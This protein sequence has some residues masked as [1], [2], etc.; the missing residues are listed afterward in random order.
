MYQ[1]LLQL[2]TRKRK[3][4]KTK[5]A[6]RYRQNYYVIKIPDSNNTNKR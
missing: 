2:K 4:T 1:Q 5:D 3:S 6:K